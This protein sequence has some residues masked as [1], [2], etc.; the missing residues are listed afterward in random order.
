MKAL[1]IGFGAMGTIHARIL[2]EKSVEIIGV[3]EPNIASLGKARTLHRQSNFFTNLSS[4]LSYFTTQNYFPDIIVI[5][6]NTARHYSILEELLRLANRNK[7]FTPKRL[8]IEK[9]IVETHEEAISIISRIQETFINQG[10]HVCCGYLMRQS[11]AI[12]KMLEEIDDLLE[13]QDVESW[14]ELITS[15]IKFNIIWKKERIP[16][17]PSAGVIQDESTHAVDLIR[18]ILKHLGIDTDYPDNIQVLYADRSSSIIDFHQQRLLYNITS[19]D[20]LRLTPFSTLQYALQYG[21]V[22]VN[23]LSSFE[24]GPLQ[25]TMTIKAGDLHIHLQFDKFGQDVLNMTYRERNISFS[26]P[27]NQKIANQWATFIETPEKSQN[28]SIKDAEIDSYITNE[29]ELLANQYLS[30]QNDGT[31]PSTSPPPLEQVE[32]TPTFTQAKKN[33]P[34][35]PDVD[36]DADDNEHNL[37]AKANKL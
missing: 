11:G 21:T 35:L 4:A 8:F 32:T 27:S 5:S 3:V 16:N 15:H 13:N 23:G 26:C 29:M 34:L 37:K 12:I 10:C 31:S 6:V 18:L 22:S 25:R 9:P 17:R 14:L 19:G 7:L 1:I 30:L 36:V 20:D 2:E 28:S 24:M 33:N